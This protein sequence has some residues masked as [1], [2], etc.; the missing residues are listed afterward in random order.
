MAYTPTNW[1]DHINSGNI[2]S[3]TDNE[4]GTKTIQYAGEVIQEGTPMAAENFNHMEQGIFEAFQAAES[5]LNAANEALRLLSEKV[6]KVSGNIFAILCVICL[7]KAAKMADE[8]LEKITKKS[9][10]GGLKN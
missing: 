5:A 9:T 4:N 10:C 1:I 7:G 8:M 6:E 2:F 3:V